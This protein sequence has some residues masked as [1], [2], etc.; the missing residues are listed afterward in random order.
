M[1]RIVIIFL[2][3]LLQACASQAPV[4]EPGF[5][6]VQYDRHSNFQ[7]ASSVDW[8]GYSK[9]MLETVSVDFREDWVRDQE[10][11]YDNRVREKDLQRIK[12]GLSELV[13]GVLSKDMGEAGYAV[14]DTSGADVML[15]KTRV[16]DL[17]VYA[18][19]RVRDH[20]GFAMADSKGRM[21]I[22]MDIHDA[23]S[24]EMLATSRYFQEDPLD[25]YMERATTASNR[26]AFRMMT[27]RWT[28]WLLDGL[29]LA[30]L[31][32]AE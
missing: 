20:I 9:V 27:K 13:G 6:V 24:G 21:A 8:S 2:V 5:E 4:P 17:D 11:L 7:V 32:I 29:A 23:V 3:L 12:T 14:V 19:D 10:R 15:F 1:K 26:H 18:P 28:D 25:G 31:D 22:E 30:G 16:V